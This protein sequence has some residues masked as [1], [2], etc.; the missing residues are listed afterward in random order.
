MGCQARNGIA[1]TRGH[2]CRT[3]WCWGEGEGSYFTG[4]VFWVVCFILLSVSFYFSCFLEITWKR[5]TSFDS[6]AGTSHPLHM[7]RQQEEPASQ[8][9]EPVPQ[10]K[11]V[12]Y[13]QELTLLTLPTDI[14]DLIFQ[15]LS[16]Q[17]A[18]N[19]STLDHEHRN[20]LKAIVF[21][22]SVPAG[23]I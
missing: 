15:D 20:V 13:N 22:G 5:K 16:R 11:A 14:L 18:I 1:N 10:R 21:R 17:D 4:V 23:T 9:E 12:K 8:K 19:L 6:S 7:K 2:K 3:I